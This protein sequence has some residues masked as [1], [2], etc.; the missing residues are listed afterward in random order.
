M[1]EVAET[2]N[3]AE[4]SKEPQTVGWINEVTTSE[5]T[6]QVLELLEQGALIFEQL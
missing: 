3:F 4:T 1:E 5:R 6:D 2:M